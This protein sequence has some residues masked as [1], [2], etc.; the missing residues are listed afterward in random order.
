MAGSRTFSY[1]RTGLI[2]LAFMGLAPLGLDGASGAG[3]ADAAWKKAGADE[4]LRQAIRLVVEDQAAAQNSLVVA[5]PW[6]Q[7]QELTAFDG[8]TDIQFGFSVSVS[9]DT[10]VV[11][12]KGAYVFVRSGGSW[13]LQQKLTLS[14]SPGRS[15]YLSQ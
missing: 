2:S 5:P 10:A 6:M 11:G 13:S 3:I 12:G 8:A 7:Q 4:G 9:G 15:L 14:N 1:V